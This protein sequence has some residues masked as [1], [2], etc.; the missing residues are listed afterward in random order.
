MSDERT[1][2]KYTHDLNNYDGIK[3]NNAVLIARFSGPEL[4]AEILKSSL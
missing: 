2:I 4:V 1:S 3:S